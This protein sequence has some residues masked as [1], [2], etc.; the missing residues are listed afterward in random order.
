MSCHLRSLVESRDSAELALLETREEHDRELDKIVAL[1]SEKDK[2]ISDLF[3]RLT[4]CPTDRELDAR[5]AIAAEAEK[6]LTHAE[7]RLLQ[8]RTVILASYYFHTIVVQFPYYLLTSC[9]CDLPASAILYF[10]FPD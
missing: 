2:Q 1:L 3:E 8:V 6:K 5:T 10:F 9:K 4:L 7:N